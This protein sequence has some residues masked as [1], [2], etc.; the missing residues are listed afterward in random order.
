MPRDLE[1]THLVL[2]LS[3][4]NSTRKTLLI[5]FKNRTLELDFY[6]L[7]KSTVL[8]PTHTLSLPLPGPVQLPR[9]SSAQALQ[10]PRQRLGRF[11]SSAL[12]E[13]FSAWLPATVQ[14]LS[15]ISCTHGWDILCLLFRL[16]LNLLSHPLSPLSPAALASPMEEQHPITPEPRPLSTPSLPKASVVLMMAMVAL[17]KATPIGA[18]VSLDHL[19][20]L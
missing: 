7:V 5:G 20:P 3:S 19:L 18:L 13:A 11:T 2:F 15:H 9:S 14:L 12:A 16:H 10:A 6:G 1:E 8:V 17:S 4:L